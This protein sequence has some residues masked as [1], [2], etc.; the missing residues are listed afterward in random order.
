[1]PHLPQKPHGQPAG[2]N[3][4]TGVREHAPPA[5]PPQKP[6]SL[7]HRLT[8]HWASKHL[9]GKSGPGAQLRQGFGKT[10]RIPAV[11]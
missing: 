7:G 9:V 2:Q 6:A 8:L 4:P 5:P 10:P 11:F 3:S 1:M